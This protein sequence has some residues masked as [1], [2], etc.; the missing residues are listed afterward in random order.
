LSFSRFVDGGAGRS[1]LK[2]HIRLE[3]G[4]HGRS[5]AS[6]LAFVVG[7][8]EACAQSGFGLHDDSRAERD[9]RR[10]VRGCDRNPLFARVS[11]F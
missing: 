9:E 7:V 2:Q 8:G 3:H 4:I 11:F 5:D 6:A 1:D 10:D